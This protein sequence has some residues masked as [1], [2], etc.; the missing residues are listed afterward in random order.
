[1]LRPLAVVVA[2]ALLIAASSIDCSNDQ[3]TEPTA[4]STPAQVSALGEA[5]IGLALDIAQSWSWEIVDPCAP[6]DVE[7]ADASPRSESGL[8]VSSVREVVVADIV[9]YGMILRVGPG[10]HDLVGLHRVVRERHPHRPIRTAKA[11]FMDHGAGKD[12][13]GNFLPGFKSPRLPDDFGLAVHLA[14]ADVDVWGLDHG[15]TLVPWVEGMDYSFMATWGFQRLVDELDLSV[16]LAR[17][18]RLITGNGNRKLVLSGYSAGAVAGYAL[19]G[20]ETQR[21]QGLRNVRA[22]I[23]VDYGI[24]YT[25]R[26]TSACAE[27]AYYDEIIGAGIYTEQNFFLL[28]GPLALDDPDGESPYFPGLTNLQ[29]ILTI[30]ASPTEAGRPAHY[31]A[32][33]FDENGIASGLQYT[34]LE[35][36]LDFWVYSPE[37]SQPYVANR[38]GALMWCGE[39]DMPWDDHVGDIAVPIFL[40]AAAGGYGNPLQWGDITLD[41][42]ASTDITE[43]IVSLH[44]QGEEALDYGHV[45]LYTADNAPELVWQPMLEWIEAHSPRDAGIHAQDF[46]DR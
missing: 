24:V 25:D 22:Y 45:D 6:G 18:L 34:A 8:I 19:L 15:Y 43:L 14:Q 40:I 1:M 37:V 30:G 7:R 17:M 29:A 36:Y 23:P 46:A 9:H 13:V 33:I 38:E 3:I 5:S 16:T 35:Q 42:V 32:G 4:A 28:L 39:V 2:I 26:A 12:F 41:L 27:V 44:P 20:E 21:P 10:E 31:W 11:V